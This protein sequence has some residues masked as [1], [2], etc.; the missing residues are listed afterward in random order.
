MYWAEKI[1]SPSYI[2]LSNLAKLS[3]LR[4][5]TARENHEIGRLGTLGNPSY[6]NSE[7]SVL[8]WSGVK[9]IPD[10]TDEAFYVNDS[11][12]WSF[13]AAQNFATKEFNPFKTT[14]NSSFYEVFAL[15]WMLFLGL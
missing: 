7:A 12:S 6:P 11:M 14:F 2:E 4:H 5:H 3:Y 8:D 13:F 1:L 10:D 15:S 9:K